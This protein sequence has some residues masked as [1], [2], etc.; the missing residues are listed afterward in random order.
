[1]L[2][3]SWNAPIKVFNL[4]SSERRKRPVNKHAEGL[5]DENAEQKGDNAHAQGVDLQCFLCL[6][7]L[8]RCFAHFSPL[9]AF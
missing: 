9:E 8:P 3:T 5:Y 6:N 4:G 7:E 1:M 2:F